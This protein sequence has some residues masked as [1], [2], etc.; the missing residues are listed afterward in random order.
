MN[1][2]S[3]ISD[4]ALESPVVHNVAGE[5]G[6]H[7][8][9]GWVVRCGASWTRQ[10]SCEGVQRTLCEGNQ[11]GRGGVSNIW[12]ALKRAT[13]S[14]TNANLCGQVTHECQNIPSQELFGDCDELGRGGSNSLGCGGGWRTRICLGN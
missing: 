5:S 3:F 12:L 4:L 2:H 11:Q 1:S 14:A 6:E 10:S 7:A 8:S 13:V 9:S